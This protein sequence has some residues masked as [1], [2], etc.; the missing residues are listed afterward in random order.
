MPADRT[1]L[2]E[3]AAVA[4][5]AAALP[6]NTPPAAIAA[7]AKTGALSAIVNLVVNVRMRGRERVKVNFRK[8]TPCVLDYHPLPAWPRQSDEPLRPRAS[9]AA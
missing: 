1:A 2:T 3:C 9:L 8:G 7:A 6:A 5:R 4:G